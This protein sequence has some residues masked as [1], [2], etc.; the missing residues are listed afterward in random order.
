RGEN[1]T[2]VA[3]EYPDLPGS[4]VT[5]SLTEG[6]PPAGQVLGVSTNQYNA[7]QFGLVTYVTDRAAFQSPHDLLRIAPEKV[8]RTVADYAD[9]VALTALAGH[10]IDREYVNSV[11]GTTSLLDA[12]H[13]LRQ[14][15]VQPTDAGYYAILHPYALRGLAGESA[16]NGYIDVTSH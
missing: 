1:F 16:L 13:E 5:A 10:A 7:T 9:N 12:V 3:T 4:V 8:A 11:L 14:R 15:N 6:T 2:I